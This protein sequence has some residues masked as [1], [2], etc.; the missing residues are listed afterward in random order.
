[1]VQID[2]DARRPIAP[3]TPPCCA[4]PA[5]GSP[6]DTLSMT[7]LASWCADDP[8][9]DT[10]TVD[11]IVPM[12]F[13]MGPTPGTS[14][15][16]SARRLA[17]GRVTAQRDLATDEWRASSGAKQY[18]F[19]PRPWQASTWTAA[20]DRVSH[21][22]RVGRLVAI[23]FA[24]LLVLGATPRLIAPGQ[25][26]SPAGGQTLPDVSADRARR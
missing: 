20:A 11:E 23:G 10:T 17:R 1:M 14:S 5:P 18:V 25:R 4:T 16:V 19:N 2:F 8:W 22:M 6:L 24:V 7:A 13:Q 9:I 21:S 3:S 26:C 12:L 15:R